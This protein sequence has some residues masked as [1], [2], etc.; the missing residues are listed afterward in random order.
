MHLV[1]L[2]PQNR[3]TCCCVASGP[4]ITPK[5]T[6]C[7]LLPAVPAVQ[8]DVLNV[9]LGGMLGGSIVWG[10]RAVINEPGDLLLSASNWLLECASACKI[11][12]QPLACI[13]S[14]FP[15]AGQFFVILGQAAPASSNFF[16]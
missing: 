7:L 13:L 1:L 14:L 5:L 6:G 10:L 16:M 8:H 11:D 15:H 12:L 2:R 4:A 3:F 9:F